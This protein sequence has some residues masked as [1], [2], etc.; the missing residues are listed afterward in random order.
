MYNKGVYLFWRT[1]IC[2]IYSIKGKQ[3]VLPKPL[4]H[5]N[6]YRK[7]QQLPYNLLQQTTCDL[8]VFFFCFSH[9]N[10]HIPKQLTVK[11]CAK[12]VIRFMFNRNYTKIIKTRICLAV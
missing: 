2:R 9:N 1:S 11:I 10:L 3:F 12:S 7:T 6:N 8:C 4:Q 5:Q